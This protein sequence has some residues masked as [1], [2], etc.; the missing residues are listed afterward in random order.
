MRIIS[1]KVNNF[2]NRISFHIRDTNTH[3][4]THTDKYPRKIYDKF[5]LPISYFSCN[6]LLCNSI[7]GNMEVTVCI[8]ALVILFGQ[9]H[10]FKIKTDFD[11]RKHNSRYFQRYRLVY[12]CQNLGMVGWFKSQNAD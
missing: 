9:V 7:A 3:T 1:L 10:L 6:F 2:H 8:I 12:D 11:I 5:F 4:H